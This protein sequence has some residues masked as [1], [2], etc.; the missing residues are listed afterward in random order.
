M[1]IKKDI[2]KN[3]SNFKASNNTLVYKG[4]ETGLKNKSLSII[5][6][7][8][9]EESNVTGFQID[10]DSVIYSN[11]N[12]ETYKYDLILNKKFKLD[13]D[14]IS[15]YR[16]EN[17]IFF[18]KKNQYCFYFQNNLQYIPINII[19]GKNIVFNGN[20]FSTNQEN[21]II[22]NFSFPTAHPLWHFPLS[23]FGTY[24]NHW[25]EEKPYEVQ[26]FI[27]VYKDILWVQLKN[28]QGLI[29]LEINTGV[30][31]H[32][33]KGVKKNQLT[34]TVDSY[35]DTDEYY[36]FYDTPFYIHETGKI[37]GLVADRFYEIDLNA[38]NIEPKLYGMWDKMK[39]QNIDK[40]NISPFTALQETEIF[41]SMHDQLKFGILD[42]DSKEITYVSEEIGVAETT[43]NRRQLRDL[44]VSG[45]KVY[46]LDSLQTLHIFEK[47]PENV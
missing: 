18:S 20:I 13:F 22:T 41:F 24:Q 46:V 29:G 32:R 34:G 21:L 16:L 43:T 5:N 47:Q 45:D 42:I 15:E 17:Q 25:R 38:V 35:I 2:I 11:W 27:G 23:Q 9:I 39:A 14:Q 37:I 1:F 19:G 31:K 3:V 33:F 12:N 44:Q 36:V 28:N 40:G 26:K 4:T 8:K 10:S 6:I 7:G 30:L